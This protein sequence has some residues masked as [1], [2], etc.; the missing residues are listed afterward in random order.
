M[1]PYAGPPV[2]SPDSQ[3]LAYLQYT[4]QCG[5]GAGE[6]AVVLVEGNGAATRVLLTS[7][8]P[9]FQALEW[10]ESGRLLL[11][12]TDNSRWVYDLATGQLGP[13]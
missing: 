9:E 4:N 12:G 5:G 11:T 8:T 13:G 1:P 6:S 10:P 3:S 7:S 2:W